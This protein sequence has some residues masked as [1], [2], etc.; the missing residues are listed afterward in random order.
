VQRS[1]KKG[2]R[3]KKINPEIA[4]FLCDK[5]DEDCTKSLGELVAMVDAEYGVQVSEVTV[6]RAVR[7]FHYTVK[8]VQLR[9]ERVL[10]EDVASQ[11]VRWVKCVQLIDI[12][13]THQI[14]L[15][16]HSGVQRGEAARDL[17]GRDGNVY[18]DAPETW[19]RARRTA[20]VP[21]RARNPLPELL[22][23][24]GDL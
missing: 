5:L 15:E 10:D 13:L 12:K 24:C 3:P 2:G 23:R 1:E 19:P 14:L 16:V 7:D 18:V 22:R 8:T 9:S 21:A 4:K 6:S 11:R 20:R 17:P